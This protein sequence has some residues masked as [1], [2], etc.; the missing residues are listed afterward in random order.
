MS[1]MNKTVREARIA[2]AYTRFSGLVGDGLR[3]RIDADPKLELVAADLAAHDVETAL[4]ERQ[5][6]VLITNS[7]CLPRAREVQRVSTA[8]PKTAIIMI[9]SRL[10]RA[11]CVEFFAHGASA[12]L[13]VDMPVQDILM[14]IG[15]V[16]RGGYVMPHSREHRPTWLRGVDHLTR[17]E[18]EVLELL[19]TGSSN[20]EIAQALHISPDTAHT[21]VNRILRKLG[22]HSRRELMHPAGSQDGSLP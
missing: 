10:S 22:V 3:L 18:A 16:A 20:R 11:E 19:R 12:C 15:V 1:A 8:Y 7:T 21:H 6:R 13:P 9:A 14:T 17:R 5:P 2:V 4:A